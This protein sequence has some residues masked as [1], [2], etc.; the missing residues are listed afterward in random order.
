MPHMLP[1]LRYDRW[2]AIDGDN[3]LTFVPF[4]IVYPTQ[5]SKTCAPSKSDVA[6]FYDGHEIHSVAIR[7]GHGARLSA[8]G[9]MDQTDWAVFD[10][11]QEAQD[12]I[13]ETYEIDPHTGESL[14]DDAGA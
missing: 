11:A 6:D 14:A 9:Y 8:P 7:D 4:D 1:Q 13:R 10:T 2:I 3:G 12:Y 5:N